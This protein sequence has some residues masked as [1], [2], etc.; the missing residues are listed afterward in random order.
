MRPLRIQAFYVLPKGKPVSIYK[1]FSKLKRRNDYFQQI[2]YYKD[3]LP[4][5]PDDSN[6]KASQ[7]KKYD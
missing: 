1:C 4:N 2:T 5:Y 7:Q 6:G 3:I